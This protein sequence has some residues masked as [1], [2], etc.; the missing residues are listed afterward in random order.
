MRSKG[1]IYIQIGFVFTL[2][3]LCTLWFKIVWF[4]VRDEML[5]VRS[6]A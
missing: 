2:C 5:D 1:K 3:S 6:R 4:G